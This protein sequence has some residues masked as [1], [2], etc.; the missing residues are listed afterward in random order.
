MGDAAWLHR[1]KRFVEGGPL[2]GLISN[3]TLV[4][5]DGRP[6]S[7]KHVAIHYRGVSPVVW[8]FFLE[9]YGGGP[10]LRRRSLNL[11]APEPS[12]GSPTV[13]FARRRSNNSRGRR[14]EVEARADAIPARRFWAGRRVSRADS[15]STPTPS[16]SSNDSSCVLVDH[17]DVRVVTQPGDGSC[18]FHSL[19]YGLNDGSDAASIRKE[20]ADFIKSNA[21]ASVAG[22]NLEDWVKFDTGETLEA[23]VGQMSEGG[24]GGAVEIEVFSRLKEVRV[25]VHENSQ[26]GYK[27][28]CTFGTDDMPRTVNLLYQGRKHYDV[29]L[30]GGAAARVRPLFAGTEFGEPLAH[31]VFAHGAH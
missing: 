8:A 22:L 31:Q 16:T 7:G 5:S 29:M 10:T 21:D 14:R 30:E 17:K 20:I 25:H 11:Y 27:R 4:H 24:W 13:D 1:W 18:L 2:P 3:E 19:S 12:S 15:S 23:Y 26:R 9:R 28:I 6:R